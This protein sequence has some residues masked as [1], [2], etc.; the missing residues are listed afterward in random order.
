MTP[1]KLETTSVKQLRCQDVVMTCTD[2]TSHFLTAATRIRHSARRKKIALTKL[3]PQMKEIHHFSV[4]FFHTFVQFLP[5]PCWPIFPIA[6]V[7]LASS[8]PTTVHFFRAGAHTFPSS[9]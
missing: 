8:L 3:P 2:K 9:E 1:R 5:L 6:I 7:S 4:I